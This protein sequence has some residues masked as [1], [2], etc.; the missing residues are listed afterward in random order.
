MYAGNRISGILFRVFVLIFWVV[1]CTTAK[2]ERQYP[3][4]EPLPVQESKESI[5]FLNAGLS[6]QD[7]SALEG[8]G[9]ELKGFDSLAQWRSRLY[10][11]PVPGSSGRA[12][13]SGQA[14]V[15]VGRLSVRSDSGYEKCMKDLRERALTLGANAIIIESVRTS[16]MRY[17]GSSHYFGGHYYFQGG[18]KRVYWEISAKAVI[19]R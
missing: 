2:V 17:P 12:P 10:A 4:R 13:D 5:I 6:L 11:R 3:E 8:I 15:L 18:T 14:Y 9:H 7:R 1:G 16:E 19:V